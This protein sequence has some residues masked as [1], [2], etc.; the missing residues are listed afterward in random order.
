MNDEITKDFIDSWR[1]DFGEE[2]TPEQANEEIER[3]CTFFEMLAKSGIY[4][5]EPEL[6]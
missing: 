4:Q 6:P 5:N 1:H 2:L 3:L